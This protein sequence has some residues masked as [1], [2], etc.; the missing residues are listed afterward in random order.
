M[1]VKVKRK[2][3][4]RRWVVLFFWLLVV[5]LSSFG[6]KVE[7]TEKVQNQ[8]LSEL[9]FRYAVKEFN[10]SSMDSALRLSEI[11]L[12][13]DPASSDS[14]LLTAKIL[15]KQKKY[16]EAVSEAETALLNHTWN[17]YNDIEGRVFLAGV[18]YRL[19]E[20]AA[21]Y[22]NLLPYKTFLTSKP[23]T[24]ELF[25]KIEQ[26]LG[27]D[28]DAASIARRFSRE[29]F[30]Q[31]ILAERDE[32]WRNEAL[33]R[34]IDGKGDVPY[35][36]RDALQVL[37]LLDSGRNCSTLLS[38]YKRRWGQDRFYAVH[39]LC[40]PGADIQGILAALFTSGTTIRRDE[41]RQIKKIL[42]SRN[43]LYS[44]KEY[45][46]GKRFSVSDD[47]T[48]DGISDMVTS[49]VDGR[50]Q[51]VD[52][53]MDQDGQADYSVYCTS[54][55]VHR[56]EISKKTSVA[57]TYLHYP[58]VE[59]YRISGKGTERSYVIVPY[60]VK[61]PLIILPEQ[62]VLQPAAVNPYVALPSVYTLEKNASK[63]TEKDAAAGTVMDAERVS[64]QDTIVSFLNSRGK[65]FKKREYSGLQLRNQTEDI[66]GDG[67]PD[68]F[69]TYHD[70]RCASMS[71]DENHNGYP[72][73]V[74]EYYPR[75]VVK[76][77]F[78]EDGI[79]DFMKY[80]DGNVTI[81]EYSTKMNGEFD[82]KIKTVHTGEENK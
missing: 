81:R 25:L 3:P 7:R 52:F 82:L 73:Y 51:R 19:G 48:G 10:G 5:P 54:G 22:V 70:G 24:A 44:V 33:A 58:Y 31:R 69:F 18:Q 16:R 49:I 11:A 78:N 60:S 50:I 53:D 2:V 37:I 30:A 14:R 4:V 1:T 79:F 8:L 13:F 34:L 21:A 35:Y 23:D 80:T 75:H 63:F 12:S 15:L 68:L 74:E 32:Q 61:L 28:D 55:A 56:V 6:Q 9:Y 43:I 64:S 42:D 26:V 76:W 29:G 77:D 71:Y 59:T 36:T 62:P 66:N 20:A 65:I 41:I 47:R 72:E 46:R 40:L 27:K 38:Y 17:Y 39:S 45:F 67:V 57:I